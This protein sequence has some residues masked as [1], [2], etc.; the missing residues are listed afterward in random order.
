MEVT[1]I[2][3]KVK[4]DCSQSHLPANISVPATNVLESLTSTVISPS[5]CV[6]SHKPMAAIE[7]VIRTAPYILYKALWVNSQSD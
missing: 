2:T 7:S 5:L 3:K 6:P 4:F 1:K